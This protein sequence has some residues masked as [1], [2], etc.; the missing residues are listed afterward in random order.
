[1]GTIKELIDLDKLI[2][3]IV[4]ALIFLICCFYL[5]LSSH[6]EIVGMIADDAIYLLMADYFSP[7]YSS[8]SKSAA[9]VMQTSQFPPLY[10]LLLSVLGA[11]SEK[12][13]WAHII[14][15]CCLISASFIYYYWMKQEKFNKNACLCLVF[16][17]V[18]SPATFLM[19]I[20]LWSE[21]LYLLITL[22]SLCCLNKAKNG[23]K[24]YLL[25]SMLIG[26]LPIIRVI[27]LA[28][29][30]AYFVYLHLNKIQD[31]YKY[32]ALS[33]LPYII[34]KIL[35]IN[36]FQTEIYQETLKEFYNHDTWSHIKYLFTSQLFDLWQGWHECFDIRKKL[37]SG[38]VSSVILLLSLITLVIRLLK[39]KIDSFYI[40]FYLLIIWIWPDDN[41]NMRF[42]FAIFP[43]LLFY[44]YLTF[45][46]LMKFKLSVQIKTVISTSSVLI[47]L[48]TFL[49]TNIYALNRLSVDTQIGLEKFK[50]TKYWMTVKSHKE[51][52]DSIKIIEKM[53][54]SYSHVSSFVPKKE[55]VYTI[56]QEQFMYYSR[57]LAFPLPLPE[58]VINDDIMSNLTKCSYVHVLYTTS[59]PEYPG[60]Y[61]KM[62]LKS[63][64]DYLTSIKMTEEINSPVVADLIRLD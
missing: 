59:H 27:G 2:C 13:F 52:Y 7:Y 51:A 56:H 50:F 28:F 64:F 4:A 21:H 25:A 35:S 17:F 54:F 46:M 39:K 1:M 29:I 5:Y 18:C 38:I 44:A 11:S 16:I 9:F 41:H 6:N 15:T 12:V 42:I 3:S 14:T 26:M 58:E 45:D 30:M 22:C 40:L 37:F 43:I 8:L 33:V 36:F 60:G 55:C 32:I 63:N 19:N 20:D 48:I 10:P 34:W 61:P 24:Y 53:T 49:P 23:K 57:R 31:K 47:V 62:M